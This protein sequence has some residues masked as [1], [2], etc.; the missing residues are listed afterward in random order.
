M[1]ARSLAAASDQFVDVDS[2]PHILAGIVFAS[3][4]S[5]GLYAI[6]AQDNDVRWRLGIEGASAVRLIGE[7]LEIR[8]PDVW[9]CPRRRMAGECGCPQ[10]PRPAPSV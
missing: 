10:P 2:T 7:D 4:Y 5:G 8:P 9:R 3:S 1:W 6:G